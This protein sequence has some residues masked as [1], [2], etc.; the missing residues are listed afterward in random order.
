M[1]NKRKD[2]VPP[3]RKVS[4]PSNNGNLENP[5]V[6]PDIV[7]NESD[8]PILFACTQHTEHDPRCDGN[9]PR[10]VSTESIINLINEGRAYARINMSFLGLPQSLMNGPFPGIPV[11]IY[12]LFLRVS[13]LQEII[14]EQLD[15]TKDEIDE[16]FRVMKY[17]GL[18]SIREEVEPQL[19]KQRLEQQLGVGRKPLL[20]PNGEML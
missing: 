11:E 15:I 4:M 18:R 5:N 7:W 2:R 17:N 6:P 8:P 12:D 14:L 3:T 20:G 19:R 1:A 9:C 13:V 10:I 16:R